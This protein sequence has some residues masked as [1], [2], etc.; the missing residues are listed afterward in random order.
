MD[1]FGPNM[2]L[3]KDLVE[4]GERDSVLAY[5]ELC[6]KFWEKDEGRLDQWSR[7]VKSGK[8]PDFGGN[9]SY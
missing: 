9:L 4:K 8:V 3:A 2:S 7:D 1:T 5:F 6:R